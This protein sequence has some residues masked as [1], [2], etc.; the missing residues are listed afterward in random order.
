LILLF[1]L[2]GA[3]TAA[4]PRPVIVLINGLQ[5]LGCP[6]T[7]ENTFGSMQSLLSATSQVVFF[8]NC[9]ECPG[10]SME[11]LGQAL[12]RFLD[13]Q[14]YPDGTP[15]T[16]FDA[17]AHSM[18]GLILRS[19]LAGKSDNPGEFSP[20]IP[21][22]IRKAVFI[23]TPHFGATIASFGTGAQIDELKPGSSFAFALATWNQGTDDLRGVDAIA[24]I[25]NGSSFDASDGVVRLTA[26]SL[27]F[28]R[29][30]DRTRI[31]P[32]CHVE[33]LSILLGC[34]QG[35]I[36]KVTAAHPTYA[37]VKSFLIDENNDWQ[38]I[39]T[40]IAQDGYLSAHGALD[41]TVEDAFETVVDNLSSVTFVTDSGS[42]T[43]LTAASGGMFY[44]DLPAAGGTLHLRT[45]VLDMQVPYQVPAGGYR[46]LLIKPPPQIA[47][48]I[49]AAGLVSTLSVAPGS[50]ISI[51]GSGF[52]NGTVTVN[53]TPLNLLAVTP[54]QINAYF[55]TGLSGLVQLQVTTP[56]GRHTENLLLARAV[57]A[58]FSQDRTGTGPGAITNGITQQLITSSNPAHAGDFISIYCTGLGDV[59]PTVTI[60]GTAAT[61]TFAGLAPGFIGLNQV[62]VQVPAGVR[63]AALPVIMTAD[64]NQSNTVTIS[65]Q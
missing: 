38:T 52:A 65:I 14:R 45:G 47:R 51:Y 35:G 31:V 55:P 28:A 18:G 32:Y 30:L 29:P 60:G 41:L 22:R 33:N 26:A 36:A 42:T 59:T 25:G 62:N 3:I 63:G 1:G 21:S 61:V 50:Y 7:S 40:A 44:G 2:A 24:V 56:A 48:T 5:L 9:A 15:V 27:A 13:T 49:P 6:S 57:P 12:G 19:Y 8:N 4:S 43:Q 17:I 64:G 53:G 34:F 11:Q 58:I 46:A 54:G 20:P 37:I 23:A 10:C 16:Q 39:G